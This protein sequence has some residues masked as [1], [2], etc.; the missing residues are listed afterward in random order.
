LTAVVAQADEVSHTDALTFLPNRKSMIAE[1]QRQ[2]T[3]AERY[4]VPLSVSMIDIDN[5]KEINDTLGH[6]VGDQVLRFIASQMRDR[7]REPD[8][9]GRYGGDEFLVIL[10]NSTASG[11]AEQATRLN[12]QV[13]SSPVVAG[14]ELIRVTMSIGITQYQPNSDTWE[15]LLE[16][17]DQ[18]MYQA[19]HDGRGTWAIIKA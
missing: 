17:A 14:K 9:L 6:G 4:G 1:L 19:K 5:F 15:T 12:Q 7:I 16:R 10:P 8:V 18:A 3:Y 2:V 11:A 13:A